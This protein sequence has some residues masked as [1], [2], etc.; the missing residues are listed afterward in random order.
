MSTVD[1]IL[2]FWWCWLS[3]N[4]RSWLSRAKARLGN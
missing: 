2:I 3:E 4:F 1:N